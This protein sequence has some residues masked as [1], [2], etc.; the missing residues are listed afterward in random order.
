MLI[1]HF[2]HVYSSYFFF[3]LFN[4][5]K[6]ILGKGLFFAVDIYVLLRPTLANLV[7]TGFYGY[8]IKSTGMMS[9]LF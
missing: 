1:Q 5:F 3:I 9:K 7:F 2:V 8:T 4:F 6:R